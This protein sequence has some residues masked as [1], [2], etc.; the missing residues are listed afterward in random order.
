MGISSG[1]L[2]VFTTCLS[3]VVAPGLAAEPVG[4]I[5]VG[6][7][8]ISSN[9][10]L[11][12]S[13]DSFTFGLKLNNGDYASGELV[14]TPDAKEWVPWKSPSFQDPI[15]FS[16]DS[17]ESITFQRESKDRS[18]RPNYRIS[19]VNGSS[20]AGEIAEITEKRLLI[21]VPD[22]GKLS[23]DRDKISRVL[24]IDKSHQLL[25]SGPEG[26]QWNQKTHWIDEGAKIVT[27]E[28]GSVLA[29]K[30]TFPDQVVYELE[31]SWEKECNFEFGICASEPTFSAFAKLEVWD[32]QL[33]VVSERAK[34]A[35]I[36]TIQ[37][38]DS[39]RS[40]QL[41]IQI[42]VDRTNG[43]V[44]VV[45]SKG[46]KPVTLTVPD[47]SF[48]LNGDGF[49]LLNKAGSLHLERLTI[50]T[51]NGEAPISVDESKSRILSTKGKLY[52]GKVKSYSPA[53]QQL[54][55]ADD[56]TEQSIAM[57]DLREIMFAN[58]PMPA[59]GRWFVSTIAGLSISGEM[60][61]IEQSRIWINS[62]GIQGSLGIPI[63]QIIAL[64]HSTAKRV[65]TKNPNQPEAQLVAHETSLRGVLADGAIKEP[66]SLYFKPLSAKDPSPL[67]A[68]TSARLVYLSESPSPTASTSR[69]NVLEIRQGNGV[70]IQRMTN[71]S[72]SRVKPS[73]RPRETPHVLH[74]TSGDL[75]PCRVDSIDEK[76]IHISTPIIQAKFIPQEQVSAV[77]LMPDVT[78]V[79][80]GKF[81]RERLLTVPRTQRDSPPTHLV[82][83]V[84]G[85]YLRCRLI[86]MNDQSLEAEV[87]L[88]NRLISRSG[89]ARILWLQS[90]TA[91][92][93]KPVEPDDSKGHLIQ[94]VYSNGNRLT[95]HPTKVEGMKLF[96]ESKLVGE[97]EVDLKN[98]NAILIGPAIDKA[99][100]SLSFQQWK[101]KPAPDPLPSESTE[102]DSS[103]GR[104]SA[105]IGKPAPDFE[106]DQADGNKFRL[107]DTKGS[108]VVLDFW[109]SWCGPCLQ[110]MPQV[111]KVA[112]E[113]ADKKVVLVGVNL[114]ESATKVKAALDRLGINLAVALDSNG[115]VAEEYGATA[116]P[117]TVIIDRAGN[118]S[119][120][121]VGA[122]PRFDDVL[123]ETLQ[124]LID[125]DVVP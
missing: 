25:F 6:A 57:S 43:K 109:A 120:V 85:D 13:G 97:C 35:D 22:I 103:S 38:I 1:L 26:V 87:R 16:A 8:T 31:L 50:S 39:P 11:E 117:Q 48:V 79:G 98:L 23:V 113:F 15:S 29:L 18:S 45:S 10:L 66:A 34:S 27:R 70:V 81:K 62:D 64:R 75:I 3:Q 74:L 95:F 21:E 12:A 52:Y 124:K 71:S 125:S 111:E 77:E 123:R 30:K 5:A 121:F 88:D 19:L 108:I 33:V 72:T 84:T 82:R 107:V 80:L 93:S 2:L 63:D 40:G 36:Q 7:S 14:E 69:T 94:A 118:V 32:D 61:K 44:I 9:N 59:S 56:K 112:R 55:I 24:R 90:N 99:T 119:H 114:E 53:N 42:Y 51:W 28:P 105:L 110:T 89:V 91:P 60:E 54:V 78:S 46:E 100:T 37:K 122:N 116:I 104:E 115:D 47:K 49:Y 73:I 106:L 20:L 65:T 83:S 76:G 41:A 4:P 17:I 92:A 86:S 67:L 101:L 68:T 58:K 96:G 102:G